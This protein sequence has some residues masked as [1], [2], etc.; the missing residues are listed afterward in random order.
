MFLTILDEGL[1]NHGS[2]HGYC[3]CEL[4][5]STFIHWHTEMVAFILQYQGWE[6]VKAYRS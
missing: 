3:F 6:A 4:F 2:N 1:V 5:L